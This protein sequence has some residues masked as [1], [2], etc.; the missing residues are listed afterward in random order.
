MKPFVFVLASA[1]FLI[2]ESQPDPQTGFPGGKISFKPPKMDEEEEHST[3]MPRHF[4]CQ[5]CQAVAY[6]LSSA[7]TTAHDKLPSSKK[8]LMESAYTDI[9]DNVCSS[10]DIWDKYGLKEADGVKYLSGPG[11]EGEQHAGMMHGGGKWPYRIM[12]MCHEL[13][14]EAGDDEVYTEFLKHG[15]ST[16]EDF[17][18]HEESDSCTEEQRRVPN[19]KEEL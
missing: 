12:A 11:T 15:G 13:V 4:R 3:I 19:T 14:G 6:Q 18:C 9:I 10:I 1:V 7:L 2:C 16:L 5:G 8:R 17:L